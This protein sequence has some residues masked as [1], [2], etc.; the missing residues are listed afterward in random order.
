MSTL[1]AFIYNSLS[2]L[3]YLNTIKRYIGEKLDLL[4]GLYFCLI[5]HDDALGYR[6]RSLM[7]LR[8]G[9]GT[10]GDH[11]SL[12][13]HQGQGCLQTRGIQSRLYSCLQKDRSRIGVSLLLQRHAYAPPRSWSPGGSSIRSGRVPEKGLQ[14]Q[15]RRCIG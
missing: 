9:M 5:D 13:K 14:S 2:R 4:M 6:Q 1:Y 3:N 11:A 7:W 12:R 8:L 15:I 10:G